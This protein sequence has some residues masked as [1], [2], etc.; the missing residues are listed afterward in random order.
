MLMSYVIINTGIFMLFRLR[1]IVLQASLLSAY[2]G[3]IYNNIS[4]GMIF[5]G[6]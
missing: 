6:G 4:N 1:S 2:Y 5:W 3:H